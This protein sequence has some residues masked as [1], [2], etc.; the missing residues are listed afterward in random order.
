MKKDI[1]YY[2]MMAAAAMSQELAPAEREMLNR[3]LHK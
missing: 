2:L 3:Y 1:C